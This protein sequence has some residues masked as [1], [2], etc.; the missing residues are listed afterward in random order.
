MRQGELLA[1]PDRHHRGVKAL[2]PGRRSNFTVRREIIASENR[3]DVGMVK[4]A[5]ADPADVLAGYV[6]KMW[7]QAQN[8]FAL[9]VG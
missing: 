1:V 4:S 7:S 9:G 3:L 5:V 2:A 8:S 6:S